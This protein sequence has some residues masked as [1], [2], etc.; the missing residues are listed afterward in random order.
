MSEYQYYKFERLDGYLDAKARQALRS[1]SSRAEISATSFQVYYTYSDLKAEPFELMLKYF[2]IGFYYADWGSIDIYIKL[3]AGTLPDPLLGFSSDGLHVHQSDEWQLLIFSIEEYYEYFDDE[4]ADDFFQHLAGLRSGLMQGDWH[5]VYFMWL[6]AFNCNDEVGQVP[7][8]QFD[9]EHLSEEEQ[10]FAALYDIPL[11]LVK[12]LAIVL[13]EQPS[14]QAKQAQ[15]QFDTWLNNLTQVE[16]DTLLRTLFE[17]GQLTRHQALALT[18]KEQANTDEIYQYWLTP[19]VISPFIEQ[20]QSQFQQ[21]QAAA[22]AKKLALEKA[23]KE[24]VLTDIYNQREHYWQ[25]A[26]EQADR[27]CASGYDAASRYLHQLFEA[28][29]FKVD[30]AV[31]EQRFKHFVVVN[32]SRKALL[33]RLNNLL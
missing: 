2:D 4:H 25:Q 13:N 27:T 26:Q 24:K 3:P 29:Q 10:A 8:I 15:F 6:K 20:A 23:E 5:L 33:N 17:Q 18:R 14:H 1:I 22:L 30:E 31:F 16:K 32:T 28:Y 9:F 19:E 7:L 11:A 12:A 21:E